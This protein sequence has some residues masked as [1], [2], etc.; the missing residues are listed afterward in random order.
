MEQITCGEFLVK[1]LEAYGINTIFGIPGVHTIEFYRGLKQTNIQHISPRHEQGAGFMADGYYRASGKVAA[2]FIIT[3]PGMT[4]ILTAMGQAY[5][6]SI[7]ML[8]ISSVNRRETLGMGQGRLHELPNQKE[9]ISGVCAFNHTLMSP[10]E[11]PAVLAKAFQSFNSQRPR[12]VHIEIPL[13]VIVMPANHLS[14]KQTPAFFKSAG[15]PQAITQAFEWLGQSKKP[16]LLLGGGAIGSASEKLLELAETYD[17]P[18][19]YTINAKGCFPAKHPLS[20]GSNQ[21]TV[22]ARQLIADADL[23]LALGT[24][25][26]ETDYDVVFDGQFKI[27]G[28]LI[29][30]D[31][32]SEQLNTNFIADLGIE[33]DVGYFVDLLLEQIQNS[34]IQ[35]RYVHGIS[36]GYQDALQ[37]RDVLSNQFWPVEWRY[38]YHILDLIQ[39]AFPKGVFVG[40]STQIVYSGNHLFEA[41]HIR[42]WF[43]ASTGYGTLGYALPAAIGASL[44]VSKPVFALVGD[45]GMQFTINELATAVEE[46]MPLIVLLWNNYGYQEIKRYMQNNS[47]DTI[48]VD[49]YTPD[50]VQIAQGYGCDACELQ[51]TDSLV[52]LIQESLLKDKPTVIVIDENRLYSELQKI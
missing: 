37:V 35:K 29:R 51:D 43:N 6:D 34:G 14:V 48:G 36:K 19:F 16:V 23:V 52:P 8:V 49:I 22:S 3:G 40:D 46:K 41:N 50:F 31:I 13:D 39:K 15:N 42:Q 17:M 44:S 24:E 33:S 7:P 32:D 47:I 12:P 30:V 10:D 5:A 28:K 18:T 2:C 27:N 20:L 45:G 9:L 25:L 38:Q 21:S 1:Q 26:G 4:N 11:L